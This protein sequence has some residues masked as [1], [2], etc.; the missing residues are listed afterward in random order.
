MKDNGPSDEC[1]LTAAHVIGRKHTAFTAVHRMNNNDQK[2]KK[3]KKKSRW[4]RNMS[5]YL[6]LWRH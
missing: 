2:K 6:P 1:E 3:K 4:E 5:S